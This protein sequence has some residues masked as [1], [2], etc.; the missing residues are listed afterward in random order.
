MGKRKWFLFL[1][2]FLF[3]AFPLRTK[4]AYSPT[5]G[6]GACHVVTKMDSTI[7]WSYDTTT[8]MHWK[9]LEPQAGVYNFTPLDNLINSYKGQ[10]IKIWLSIQTV[11]ADYAPAPWVEQMGA[12]WFPIVRSDGKDHGLFAPWDQVYLDRLRKLLVAVNNHLEGKPQDY[13]DTVGGIMMMSGGMYGEMQ[14]W[15]GNAEKVLMESIQLDPKN[16]NDILVFRQA[17]YRAVLNLVDIYLDVFYSWPVALQVGYNSQFTH[18]QSGKIMP[19]DQAVI[20]AK[21]PEHGS[22]LILKWNGLDP[23]NVGDGLDEVRQRSVDYY[24]WLFSTYASQ[25]QVGFE[26]G[27]PWLYGNPPTQDGFWTPDFEFVPSRFKNAFETARRSKAS[28]VCFQP[29][30]ISGL[31]KVK[32]WKTFDADLERVRIPG[33]PTGK[34][35][36]TLTPTG[37]Q[38]VPTPTSTSPPLDCSCNSVEGRGFYSQGDSNCDGQTNIFD[39]NS[40]FGA[41]IRGNRAYQV[42]ADFSCNGRVSI[43]D[44]ELWRRNFGF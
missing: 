17:Y 26:V 27:H 11:A 13:K 8:A 30:M 24:S 40:W 5:T 33:F 34:P 36:V 9:T 41:Y 42:L 6:I 21:V 16:N 18:P 37:K 22:R 20:E 15:S 7:Q 23:T 2:L 12:K 35:R 10:N 14:L 38:R 19:V 1:L 39:Y 25:T 4:A 28:F 3:L 44:Y 31:K 32:S 43:D 29:E